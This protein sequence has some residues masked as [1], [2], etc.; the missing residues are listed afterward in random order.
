MI[1]RTIEECSEARN[2]DDPAPSL[3]GPQR[4]AVDTAF[5]H[6]QVEKILE[7][8]KGMIESHENSAIRTWA[9]VTLDAL[10]LRSPTSLKVALAAI[11]KGKTINLQEALQM[12]LNI[13][14]AYCASSGASPDFHTGVTA[15]LVDKI[16]ERPAWYPAT[17]GEVSDS[18]ISKKFFSDYTPTSGTSPA[19]AFPEALDPAKGTRFSPVLFALP[20]E[21]EIRQL[22]DG[23]HASSGATAITLQE[24][25]NKLN[26]LRQGKMG[27]REK[28]LEVVER[29]CVQDE[30][31]ETGEKYLRWKSSAA[32]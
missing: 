12:E 23:S 27:I 14:T 18:E 9:Q 2:A 4:V 17:L 8:L 5:A 20:T 19:L 26:L 3:A 30:E 32:H 13:A 22:V 21:Q 1:D 31:K 7:S 11:R 24:L 28:V 25:L 29:C 6:N 16:I 15:V 10:E